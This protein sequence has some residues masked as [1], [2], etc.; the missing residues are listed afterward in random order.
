A[1]ADEQRTRI[2]LV[3]LPEATP[4]HEALA[5]QTDLARS[6]LRPWTW[7]VNASLALTGTTDPVLRARAADESR[8]FTEITEASVRRPVVVPWQPETPV[9]AQA[10]RLLSG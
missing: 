2:I 1:L 6:G 10:L 9:G 5:L 7:V 4:V 8:W 3:A